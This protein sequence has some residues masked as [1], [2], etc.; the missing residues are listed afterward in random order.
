MAISCEQAQTDIE[1]F[2]W[3]DERT[4]KDGAEPE[5]RFK[6]ALEHMTDSSIPDCAVVCEPCWDHYIRLKAKYLVLGQERR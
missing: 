6:R 3:H 1:F 4:L 2:F 5:L